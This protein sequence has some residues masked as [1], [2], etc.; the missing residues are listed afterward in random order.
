MSQTETQ[1]S[2]YQDAKQLYYLFSPYFGFEA[3]NRWRTAAVAVIFAGCIVSSITMVYIQNAFSALNLLLL[4]PGMTLGVFGSSLLACTV[5]IICY[6]TVLSLC[7]LATSW[8][9]DNLSHELGRN[10]ISKWIDTEAFYGIKFIHS[11]DNQINPGVVLGDDLNEICHSSTTLASTFTQ[12]LLDFVVGAYQLWLLSAPMVVTLFSMTIA[13]PGY[14]VIGALGYAAAYG[15][16]V[17]LIDKNLRSIDTKLKQKKDSFNTQ[18]HHVEE[19]AETIAMK[20]GNQVEKQD[21]LRKLDKVSLINA[22]KRWVSFL[23]AF[24]Q[25]ISMNVSYLFGLALSAPGVI[26]GKLEP[27]NA[28]SVAQYFTSVVNFFAWK[29]NNTVAFSSLTVSLGR[30]NAFQRL[31]GQWN[32]L[33]VAK[34][35]NKT[36]RKGYFGVKDLTI[37]TPERKTLLKE[38]TFTIPKGKIILIQGPSGIGK[39]TLFRCLADLWPY[40][41]GSLILPADNK[42]GGLRVH[43]IPQQPYFPCRSTLIDAINYPNEIKL[44][45]QN[46]IKIIQLMKQLDFS[47]TVIESLDKKDDWG[48]TL[49]GG[50][51]QRIAVISA[52]IKNPDI[53]FIDEGTNGLDPKNKQ[54]VESALKQHL[55]GKT[56][57]AIDHHAEL[58]NAPVTPFYDYT[59]T[60]KKEKDKQSQASIELGPFQ[61]KL[62]RAR[63]FA[64][65]RR[66]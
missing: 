20:K 40:V 8:L 26:A 64:A 21:I 15:L 65:S 45:N 44:T 56:I 47:Q 52:I 54:L 24:A 62:P 32:K 46:R 3:K 10:L 30:F 35:L 7:A 36:N 28:F 31:M 58:D 14:M 18:L 53:L 39:T 9:S 63:S 27:N 11:K 23:V 42:S 6:A 5:P 61:T 41:E 1:S 19:H 13:I 34:K 33:Q 43:Y 59:L 12:A 66:L 2:L 48:K 38:S 60:M 17:H 51:K 50:E 37:S 29:K 4:T 25:T 55:K 22:T 57:V 49:S 16:I